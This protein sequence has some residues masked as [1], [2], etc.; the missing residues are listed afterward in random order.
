MGSNLDRK[1]MLYDV[2]VVKHQTC[3]TYHSLIDCEAGNVVS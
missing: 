3:L 2:T 1:V